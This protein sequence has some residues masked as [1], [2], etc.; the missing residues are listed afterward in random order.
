MKM[1]STTPNLLPSTPPNYQPQYIP[2][3]PVLLEM[4][5]KKAKAPLPAAFFNLPPLAS[6]TESNNV[7][8][9]IPAA[10]FNLPPLASDSKSDNAPNVIPGTRVSK[11]RSVKQN[12]GPRTTN[13]DE[14]EHYVLQ[15]LVDKACPK[16]IRGA[17]GTEE[18]WC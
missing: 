5:L 6:D 10:F 2:I 14:E 8:N 13:Y 12:S 11:T 16:C 17:K 1:V 18:S 15:P 9:V 7:P 3:D 4:D